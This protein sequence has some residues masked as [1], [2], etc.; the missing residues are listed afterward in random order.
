MK[1]TA[2]LRYLLTQKRVIAD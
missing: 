1:Q 2:Y